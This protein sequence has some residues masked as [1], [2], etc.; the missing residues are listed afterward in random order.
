MISNVARPLIAVTLPDM[1]ANRTMPTTPTTTTQARERPKRDPTT[2]FVTR[3]PMS[4][5]PPMAVR[6][7]RVAANRRFTR[8]LLG[9][10]QR[11]AVRDVVEAGSGPPRYVASRAHEVGHVVQEVE[12]VGTDAQGLVAW[13]DLSWLHVER[14]R[15]A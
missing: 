9:R 13:F 4:T 14:G 11:E 10:Q 15:P 5:N 2:A 7:P 1:C 8:S 6:M 12:G 3:S